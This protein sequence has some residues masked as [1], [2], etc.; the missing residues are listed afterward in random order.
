[1]LN[2]VSLIPYRRNDRE[3]FL[4]LFR[5]DANE[6]YYQPTLE[7]RGMVRRFLEGSHEGYGKNWTDKNYLALLDRQVIGCGSIA[8]RHSNGEI[9]CYVHPDYRRRGYG[10][11]ILEELLRK[12]FSEMNLTELYSFCL[13]SSR[14][15]LEFLSRLGF[16]ITAKDALMRLSIIKRTFSISA[17]TPAYVC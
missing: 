9:S 10:S 14:Q 11:E 6:M 4:S 3:A 2:H 13:P 16:T 17:Y 1:M 8:R 12:G 5:N 7:I 15:E